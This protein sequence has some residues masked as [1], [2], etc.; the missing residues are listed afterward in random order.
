MHIWILL[1][2]VDLTKFQMLSIKSNAM[3]VRK[4]LIKN[5]MLFHKL[6]WALIPKPLRWSIKGRWRVIIAINFQFKQLE[7]RS[8]KNIRAS[9]GFES[10]TSAIP[11]R[12][13]TNW[14]VKPHIGSEVNLLSAYL[15]V[16]WK[17]EF[18]I[19]ISHHFTPRE[20]KNST[21]WP[22]S[23][24]VASQL[25]W[26]SIA[27]VSRSSRVRIP[28]TEAPIFFRLLPSNCLN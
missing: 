28:L 4:W 6:N 1:L 20:G 11:V 7:G 3:H 12:C 21:N 26:S 25:S 8:L 17:D 22:R 19:Y 5:E 2:W 13:S 23:Q 27:P 15:P 18:H 10:V 9:T 24:C 14:A 16:Q